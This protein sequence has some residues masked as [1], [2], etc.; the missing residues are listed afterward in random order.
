[1]YVPS[2]PHVLPVTRMVRDN[3]KIRDVLVFDEKKRMKPRLS[4][5]DPYDT[6][7][8]PNGWFTDGIRADMDYYFGAGG[9]GDK[10]KRAGSQ[11]V[12]G[13]GGATMMGGPQSTDAK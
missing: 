4:W 10:A 13:G 1:M 8:V 5:Y 7:W 2:I 3:D 11:V 12:G 9:G 6:T